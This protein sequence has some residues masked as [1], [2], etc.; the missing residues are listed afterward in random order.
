[1][2]SEEDLGE[3]LQEHVKFSKEVLFPLLERIKNKYVG[4]T[5]SG[6]VTC[7]KCKIKGALKVSQVIHRGQGRLTASCS[8]ENCIRLME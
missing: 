3:K 4:R 7:P 8:T 5:F 6:H 2:S 1:M